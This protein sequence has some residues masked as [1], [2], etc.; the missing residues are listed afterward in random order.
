[1]LPTACNASAIDDRRDDRPSS[2][3]RTAGRNHQTRGNDGR[4]HVQRSVQEQVVPARSVVARL[5]ITY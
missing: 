4:T 3:L 1:M 2:G 5:E